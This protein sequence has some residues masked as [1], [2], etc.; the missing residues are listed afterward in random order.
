MLILDW[1]QALD[2]LG[3][4]E[5]KTVLKKPVKKTVSL[6]TLANMFN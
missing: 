6:N 3:A 1:Y 2:S 5:R 4:T